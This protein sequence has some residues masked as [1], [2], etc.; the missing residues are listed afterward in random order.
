MTDAVPQAGEYH[1]PGMDQH[2]AIEWM[3]ATSDGTAID[4]WHWLIEFTTTSFYIKSM[5]RALQ[6]MKVSIHG[7]DARH[8]DLDH[9]RF[10]VIRT[11]DMEADPRAAQRAARDGG[12]WLTDPGQ[13]PHHFIGQKINDHV[14]LITRFSTDA[15]VFLAGAPPA[16]GSDW[17]KEKATMRGMV[18]VPGKG[19]ATHV[20]VFLCDDGQPYWPNEHHVR[21]TQSGMGYIRNSLDWCLSAVVFDRSVE[22]LPDPCGDL[23]RGVPVD[24]CHRGLAAT[25]DEL[26]LLWLCEKLIPYGEN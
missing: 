2:K 15:D 4:S 13:L 25:V 16:G 5:N 11:P 24:Q 18:S 1:Y 23:R 10:D 21:A 26:G 9:F 8:P 14:R 22:Y 19:S 3:M 7:P 12:R 6:A 17:P 20:D